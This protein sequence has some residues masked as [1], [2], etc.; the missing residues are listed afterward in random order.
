MKQ[1]LR[2]S[3]FVLA[4]EFLEAALVVSRKQT[5]PG[6]GHCL[7]IEVSGGMMGGEA[8]D[9]CPDSMKGRLKRRAMKVQPRQA[10]MVGVPEFRI[11]EPAGVE[12]FQEFIV[13]KMRRR[14]RQWHN[15][16]MTRSAIA[17]ASGPDLLPPRAALAG[18]RISSPRAR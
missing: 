4:E 10:Q 17:A 6:R 2:Q 11:L 8:L 15:E 9:S 3:V 14:Q 7:V 16:I 1:I 5:D 18:V 12:C 13:A